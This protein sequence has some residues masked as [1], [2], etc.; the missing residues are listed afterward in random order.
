MNNFPKIEQAIAIHW[1]RRDLRL[2]DN[3]ALFQ[4]LS[5]GLPVLPIFI[6]DTRVLSQFPNTHDKRVSYI[7]DALTKLN[8]QLRTIGSS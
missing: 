1:F 8:E 5:S 4:A 7:Y 2:E 3:H 6:F